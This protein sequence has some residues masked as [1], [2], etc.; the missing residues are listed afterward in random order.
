MKLFDA[1]NHLQD[2]RFAHQ[3][4]S[5]LSAAAGTGVAAMVVN[6]SA[7][8][9][10]GSVAQL[11]EQH[12]M[13]IPSYGVHPWYVRGASPDWLKI[14]R[15]YLEKDPRS[16]VG[17][18]GL[19]RWKSDLP[20]EGQEEVFLDQ[21]RLARELNR[22]ASIHCLKAWG[23]LL[24][25]LQQDPLPSPGFVL[26]S[27][28]GPPEMIP[29]FAKLG[30]YFSF[31][32]YYL[33]DRKANQRATFRHVPADRLLIETDA[34]DQHLPDSLN[35]FPM[36]DQEGKPINHPANLRAVYKGLA[37]FLGINEEQLAGQVEKNFRRIFSDAVPR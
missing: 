22:P 36:H 18:I 20:Y 15:H 14:L 26:H 37:E 21:W 29:A 27:Y 13:V 34:P 35:L 12:A 23:R 28:G 2:E 10:W 31:P 33:H 7:E 1:H 24:E 17:E 32:G 3:Q 4:N 25:L 16:A 8:D 30:G 11:A 19:D 9:D 6:G 5:I